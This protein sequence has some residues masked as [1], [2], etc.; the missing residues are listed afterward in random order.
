MYNVF[1][2]QFVIKTNS[3]EIDKISKY[4]IEYLNLR[5]SFCFI[6]TNIFIRLNLQI[7]FKFST[8]D[9]NL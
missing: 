9:E 7:V 2:L 8:V 4:L 6:N 3:S 1:K 5:V